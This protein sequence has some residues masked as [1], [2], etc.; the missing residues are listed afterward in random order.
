MTLTMSAIPFFWKHDLHPNFCGNCY[1][2][3][4]NALKVQCVKMVVI[5]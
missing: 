2:M 1:F 3:V 5:Y 4:N